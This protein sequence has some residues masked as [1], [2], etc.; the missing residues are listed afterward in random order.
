[1]LHL[2]Q[3][4]SCLFGRKLARSNRAL[5]LGWA[6]AVAGTALWA[7]GLFASGAPPVLDWHS[8][9]PSWMA[10]FVP[11]LIAEL[12]LALSMAGMIPIYYARFRQ[13]RRS[14]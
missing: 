3:W 2:S 9:S 10:G 11:T 8:F 5:A 7:Y 1:M 12:G 6:V 4:L 14:Q 13:W